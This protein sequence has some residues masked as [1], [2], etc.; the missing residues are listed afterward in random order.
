LSHKQVACHIKIWILNSSTVTEMLCEMPGLPF[1]LEWN[2]LTTL[3][4][5]RRFK[6][7]FSDQP[8]HSNVNAIEFS[9][10][11]SQPLLPLQF[12]SQL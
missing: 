3:D 1:N 10:Q 12:G 6:S 7:D 2:A 4:T 5:S 11:D 9:E 8:K